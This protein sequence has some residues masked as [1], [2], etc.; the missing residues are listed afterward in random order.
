MVLV[1]QDK[2]G[3]E[4]NVA[5]T[6]TDMRFVS[7]EKNRKLN[8]FLTFLH[9][10]LLSNSLLL[11]LKI[12][13]YLK[14]SWLINY[15]SYFHGKVFLWWIKQNILFCSPLR[16]M[17]DFLI[18]LLKKRNFQRIIFVL[19][20]FIWLSNVIVKTGTTADLAF[21]FWTDQ[22]LEGTLWLSLTR[23]SDIWRSKT[24]PS[25]G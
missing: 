25:G 8:T 12:S 3:N 22:L 18:M 4:T 1:G 24:K 19:I 11:K 16:S 9:F 21:P 20:V 5:K 13:C 6:F 2:E 15:Q 10:L 17:L 14:I 23:H 7:L